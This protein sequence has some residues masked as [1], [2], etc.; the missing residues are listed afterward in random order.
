[1]FSY[2]DREGEEHILEF[3]LVVGLGLSTKVKI[4]K[5]NK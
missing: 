2:V 3:V 1:M 4:K 5:I